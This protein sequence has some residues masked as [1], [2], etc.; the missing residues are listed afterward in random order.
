VSVDGSGGLALAP[1]APT[2]A[3]DDDGLDQL[4]LVLGGWLPATALEPLTADAGGQDVV[5]ADRENNPLALVGVDAAGRRTARR[6]RPWSPGSGPHWDPAARR[7][8]AA[9]REAVG[10]ISPAGVLGVIVD[11][12]P[13]RADLAHVA[14]LSAPPGATPVGVVLVVVPVR[15]RRRPAGE[16]GWAGLTRAAWA[17]RDS[18][19]DDHPDLNVVGVV[20]PWPAGQDSDPGSVLAAAGIGAT[21]R[22][23]R[24]RDEDERARIDRLPQA[25]EREVRGLYPPAS[26]DE[27][28]RAS[29][30]APDRGAVV[31]LTGLSG[32]GKSTIARALADELADSQARRVT[33][34]DGDEVRHHLSRGLG[35]D[36][37]SR[38]A[39]ID[40]IAWVAS[41]VAAHGGIAVAA[42]IAPFAADRRAARAMAEAHGPFLLVHVSTPLAVCE[43]RDRKG[44]YARAR[45]GELPEFTGISSPYEVPDDADVTIDASVVD[46]PEA[47]RRIVASLGARLAG[48]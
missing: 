10:G 31:F 36:R 16:V 33:L 20:L 12:V 14:Q 29:R 28:L 42:P 41:L 4:E 46:V 24:L 19:A 47:V 21:Y 3:L 32:S 2:I 23:S 45:A 26:A 17:L 30:A 22:I 11:D 1:G 6:L 5:L 27:V 25:L 9:I 7:S 18:L 35:F 39:N 40:R 34:L 48:R 15:R 13:T 43:A 8:A 44:L 38:A 37:E